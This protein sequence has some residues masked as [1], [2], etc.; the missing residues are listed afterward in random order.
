MDSGLGSLFEG[1]GFRIQGVLV[2]A[3]LDGL[4]SFEL[5]ASG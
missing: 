2:Y 3:S 4:D 1:S 5:L